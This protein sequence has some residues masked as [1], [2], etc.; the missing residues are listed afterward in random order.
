MRPWKHPSAHDGIPDE[1]ITD[2]ATL[3]ACSSVC[4]DVSGETVPY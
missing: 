4:L 3:L 2:T 1:V